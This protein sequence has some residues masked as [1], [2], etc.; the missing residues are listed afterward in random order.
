MA[1]IAGTN[2]S[3]GNPELHGFSRQPE[4]VAQV[5]PTQPTTQDMIAA[6]DLLM[7]QSTRPP[8]FAQTARQAYDTEMSQAQRNRLAGI[9]QAN[10]MASRPQNRV[11]Q[12]FAAV[13]GLPVAGIGNYMGRHM[14][15]KLRAGGRPIY[16]GNRLVGV[17]HGGLLGGEVYSGDPNFDPFASRFAQDEEQ[18]QV[19]L[20]ET[21]VETGAKRC[22][23]GY[24]FDEQLGACR[25]AVTLPNQPETTAYNFYQMPYEDER[26][27]GTYGADLFYG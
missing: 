8:T 25:L 6:E 26:L 17:V 21:D 11:A 23:D 19:I 15:E 2:V 24:I 7:A 10:I 14:E 20:P 3:Y 5:A 27:L 1:R 22:A 18:R 13:T 9:V 16:D 4:P 12:G